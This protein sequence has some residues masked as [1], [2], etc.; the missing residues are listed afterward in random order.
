MNL[1]H[2][3]IQR[4]KAVPEVLWQISAAPAQAVRGRGQQRTGLPFLAAVTGT[5]ALGLV[6][7]PVALLVAGGYL[8]VH[9]QPDQPDQ[10]EPAEATGTIDQPR[11]DHPPVAH[12]PPESAPGPVAPAVRQPAAAPRSAASARRPAPAP[13]N[14]PAGSSAAA[15]E[16]WSGYD[17]LTVPQVL[18]RL[19]DSGVD[20]VAV[21]RYE[22]AHRH[23]KMVQAAIAARKASPPTKGLGA[24]RAARAHRATGQP[25]S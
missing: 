12:T 9:R 14:H 20:L 21:G 6:D 18:K 24:H 11:L 8:L 23:R 2:T 1:M 3:V 22:A 16:P 5:A 19:D 10:P 25:G 15:K 7:W 4:A 17:A 13:P